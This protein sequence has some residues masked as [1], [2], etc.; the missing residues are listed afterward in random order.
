MFGDETIGERLRVTKAPSTGFDYLR[1]DLCVSMIDF[2]SVVTSS[3]LAY[4][5]E[6]W[7]GW[8]RPF[9]AIILPAF[10]STAAFWF[11]QASFAVLALPGESGAREPETCRCGGGESDVLHHPP[12]EG[13]DPGSA[14]RRALQADA[15]GIYR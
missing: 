6:V 4:A 2:H 7:N 9:I 13:P 10:F 3:G 12:A 5:R 8:W 11:R 1:A 15:A 14:N